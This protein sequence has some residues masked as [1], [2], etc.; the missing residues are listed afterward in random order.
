MPSAFKT[1]ENCG[2]RISTLSEALSKADL[3]FKM[4]TFNLIT[5]LFG[6]YSV[7][8]VNIPL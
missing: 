2:M 5:V 8:E 4:G 3:G 1:L 6:I 7:K